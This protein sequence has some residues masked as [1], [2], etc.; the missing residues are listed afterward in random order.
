MSPLDSKTHLLICALNAAIQVDGLVERLFLVQ[1]QVVDV[2]GQSSSESNGQ[3][4]LQIADH[5]VG[6]RC[7]NGNGKPVAQPSQEPLSVA[8]DL[9]HV[10]FSVCLSLVSS[11]YQVSDNAAIQSSH[12]DTQVGSQ[13]Q[14][15]G[16]QCQQ[17]DLLGVPVG[18]QDVRNRRQLPSEFLVDAHLLRKVDNGKQAGDVLLLL[19]LLELGCL[20][21]ALF[22]LVQA[23]QDQHNQA[24]GDDLACP[25]IH[26]LG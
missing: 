21:P 1:I 18:E 25:G 22:G 12:H 3:L 7:R 17:Q 9:R 24:A 4:G 26:R 15:D 5:A 6:V 14:K 2:L 13:H 19:I 23:G 10:S 11:A 20:L 8:I 16:V